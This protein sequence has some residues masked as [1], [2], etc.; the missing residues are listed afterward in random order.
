MARP[1]WLEEFGDIGGVWGPGRRTDRQT[2]LL[3][4]WIAAF[5]NILMQKGIL[6]LTD[7]ARKMDEV[8]VRE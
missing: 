5:S 1:V 7:L 4:R 2:D 3:R 8:A 6:T